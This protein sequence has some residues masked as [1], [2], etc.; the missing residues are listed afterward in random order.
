M[1]DECYYFGNALHLKFRTK[2]AIV[3][4]IKSDNVFL[5]FRLKIET[6][7]ENLNTDRK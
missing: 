6:K 7:M 4:S 5:S 3:D 2:V 1:E